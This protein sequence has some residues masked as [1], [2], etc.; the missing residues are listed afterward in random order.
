MSLIHN[1]RVKLSATWLNTLAATTI[2]AGVVAPLVA[3]VFGLPTA[4]AVSFVGFAI[5]CAGWLCL[6]SHYF[7]LLGV[8]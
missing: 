7:L 6:V 8:S 2:A 5:A 3:V 1:E 4:G